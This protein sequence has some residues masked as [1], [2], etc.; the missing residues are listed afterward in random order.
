[1]TVLWTTST[2]PS[3]GRARTTV[4]SM[5]NIAIS[6]RSDDLGAAIKAIVAYTPTEILTLYVAALAAVSASSQHP[7]RW[8]PLKPQPTDRGV[9]QDGWRRSGVS[10]PS[11][12]GEL[13][14]VCRQGEDRREGIAVVAAEVAVVVILVAT[15][16]FAH[17]LP[18]SAVHA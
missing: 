17:A 13:A 3:A 6:R 1:M 7:R 9:K 4:S 18:N 10:S 8:P 11:P 12:S 16:A 14:A 15:I 2:S 5:T